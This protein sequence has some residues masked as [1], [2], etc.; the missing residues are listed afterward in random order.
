MAQAKLDRSR[1]SVRRRRQRG[2]RRRPLTVERLEPRTLMALAPPG[3][4]SEL[5][6]S[7]H[8]ELCNCPVCTG[9]GLDQI[10]AVEESSAG[11]AASNPLSSLPQLASNPSA[12]AKLYLDF[13][14]HF[15]ASWGNYSNATTPVFDQDGD[16][17]TFSNGELATIQQVWARAAEDY[18][19]FNIDVTTID[20]G[21]LA[22]GVVAHIAIGGNWSDWYGSSAGGVAYVGGF[23]NGAPNVGYVFEAALGNGNARY[24]AEAASHE[25]GH[26]FGLY[27]QANW[28]GTTLVESYNSGNAS[29]AP[30]MGVGYYATRTTWHN[31]ATPTSNTSYQSDLV[32]LAN[33][34]NGFGLRADDHGSTIA[35]ADPLT[36][37]GTAASASGILRASS[38]YARHRSRAAVSTTAASSTHSPSH[39]AVAMSSS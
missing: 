1:N 29:W 16:A 5:L 23:Y 39:C 14:G 8:G 19:P 10:P 15:Q 24:V 22:N 35:T 34:S 37:N 9:Q 26:L 38:V 25:A 7:G 18:A 17:T 20:P 31:G 27:H 6:L 21:S 36:I 32:I 11:P 2:K 13:N 30:I 28:S 3:V 33:A 4:D 12:A